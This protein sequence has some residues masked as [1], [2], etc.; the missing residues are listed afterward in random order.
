MTKKINWVIV[1]GKKKV[2]SN[3]NQNI[4]NFILENLR[5]GVDY[6]TEEVQ[7]SNEILS[8]LR[9]NK[10]EERIKYV[11][12]TQIAKD[13]S[14]I[15]AYQNINFGFIKKDNSLR[16]FSG[17]K[18]GEQNPLG[19]EYL[20]DAEQSDLSEAIR[21]VDKEKIAFLLKGDDILI[22]K[23]YISNVAQII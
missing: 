18:T 12:Q 5:E 16:V 7:T 3:L 6:G 17:F 23:N 19:K 10:N 11:S 21:I 13:F 15:P 1:D 2:S 4:Q 14:E 20:V 22:S 8:I 9:E